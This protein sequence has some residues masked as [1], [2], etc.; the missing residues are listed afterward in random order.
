MQMT[1]KTFQ[2]KTGKLTRSSKCPD[3][4]LPT[5]V[6]VEFIRDKKDLTLLESLIGKDTIGVASEWKMSF[7]QSQRIRLS[8]L[9]I[10]D[11]ETVFLID[12]IAL[13]DSPAL[14]Q[15]LTQ[16]VS[17]ENTVSI[18]FSFHQA[19]SVLNREKKLTFQ[20]HFAKFVDVQSYYRSVFGESEQASLESISK[21]MLK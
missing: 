21:Q 1:S 19:T 9:Q 17:N 7:S 14:D 3:M 15:I 18:G 5:N 6:T 16:I 2:L 10:C 12:L 13:G 20:N 11:E 4:K 8:L